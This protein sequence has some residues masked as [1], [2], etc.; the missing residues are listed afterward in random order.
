MLKM[1]PIT[2]STRLCAVHGPFA[3]VMTPGDDSLENWKVHISNSPFILD[4][5]AQVGCPL[6]RIKS[7]G[8]H[9]ADR[10]ILEP[11]E[12]HHPSRTLYGQSCD[13]VTGRFSVLLAV[14]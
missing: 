4:W 12:R 11:N 6:L 3:M 1:L 8:N 9:Y 5:Q 13:W 10:E 14:T 7:Y 2:G